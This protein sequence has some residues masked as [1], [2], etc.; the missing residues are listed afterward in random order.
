MPCAVCRVPCAVCRV[1]C[2]VCRVARR[3]V[4][5]PAGYRI[6]AGDLSQ[7]FVHS[8]LGL[9][10]VGARAFVPNNT[11]FLC[12]CVRVRVRVRVRVCLQAPESLEHDTWNVPTMVWS[13]GMFLCE[14]FS[15]G[16]RP[17]ATL[18]N[19]DAHDAIIS[20]VLLEQTPRQ[21]D[22]IYNLY[23]DCCRDDP[24]ERITFDAVLKT[25][26]IIV[27]QKDIPVSRT[28]DRGASHVR[29]E[30][31]VSEFSDARTSECF[32]EDDT[33]HGRNTFPNHRRSRL[34]LQ[35][36]SSIASEYVPNTDDQA[37]T[38]SDGASSDQHIEGMSPGTQDSE[39]LDVGALLPSY[40]P[41]SGPPTVVLLDDYQ[42]S[43]ITAAEIESMFFKT[44]WSG[45]SSSSTTRFK[46]MLKHEPNLVLTESESASMW[47]SFSHIRC[48]E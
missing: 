19:A 34:G 5:S 7:L 24:I 37:E 2:A 14:L 29:F 8:G 20:G 41:G 22:N 42:M 36:A 28:K 48:G 3:P 1:P 40:V 16:Q 25:L 32:T 23:E 27:E 17:Y 12:T 30:S 15:Q 46:Q 13:Y 39:Y 26:D 44:K 4:I 35:R 18:S 31:C 21:P 33:D 38:A 45:F 9:L 6:E 43:T 47:K 10:V 11:P